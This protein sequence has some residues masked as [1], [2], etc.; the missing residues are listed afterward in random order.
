[1]SSCET[2]GGPKPHIHSLSRTFKRFAKGKRTHLNATILQNKMLK[3]ITQRQCLM[4]EGEVE[5]F[6]FQY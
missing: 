1:M 4:L 3:N 2:R 6:D 5:L